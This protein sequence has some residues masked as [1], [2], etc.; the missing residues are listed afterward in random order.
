MLLVF[1]IGQDVY[2]CLEKE[3]ETFSGSVLSDDLHETRGGHESS[4]L[5]ESNEVTSEIGSNK[6]A[7]DKGSMKKRGK[8]SGSMVASASESGLDNQE[9]FST[10]SKKNQRKGKDNSSLQASDS[11]GAVK[12]ESVKAKEENLNIPS[13]EWLMQKLKML[14]P[15]F[16][17]QGLL[18]LFSVLSVPLTR[19]FHVHT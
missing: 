1:Y 15:D 17:E 4:R 10:K 3:T 11:K 16:E 9:N 6:Q 5:A 14:V 13:E 7:V 12:K 8:S 19:E 18:M 2:D